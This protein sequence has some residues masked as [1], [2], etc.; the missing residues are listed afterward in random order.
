[1]KPQ[2]NYPHIV[3]DDTFR[4]TAVHGSERFPFFYYLE[5]IYA[6]SGTAV[7]YVRDEKL[8]LPQIFLQI[9]RTSIQL[10]PVVY[11]IQYRLNCAA[12]LLRTTE[13]SVS[14]I[15]EKIRFSSAGYFCRKFRQRYQMGPFEY[16]KY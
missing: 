2:K 10:F 9:S 14:G 8:L 13:Y 12:K 16:R 4:E 5:V 11:L 1:M 3:T 15:A 6:K 7:C